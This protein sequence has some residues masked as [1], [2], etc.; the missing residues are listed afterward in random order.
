MGAGVAGLAGVDLVC[1]ALAVF[2]D[3]D[4]VGTRRHGG[5]GGN[6][7]GTTGLERAAERMAGGR[8]ALQGQ[9]DAGRVEI[10]RAHRIAIHGRDVRR[11]L[12]QKR[13]GGFTQDAV[14]APGD[15]AG[16]RRQGVNRLR[17]PRQAFIQRD[18]AP[19]RTKSPDRP[20]CLVSSW[21]ALIRIALSS[22]LAMS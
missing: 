9:A 1:F 12:G 5:A 11:R 14:R 16:F 20:P 15:G 8:L 3:H 22:A 6:P 18:H 10:G 4:L 19:P 21:M 2:L 17:N 7:H 13:D